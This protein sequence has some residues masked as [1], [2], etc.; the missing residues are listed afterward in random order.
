MGEGGEFV[1]FGEV[2][3]AFF[4]GDTGLGDLG[5]IAAGDDDFEGGFL[6]LELFGELESGDAFGHDHIGDEEVELVLVLVPEVEGLG[7]I[8][9]GGDLVTEGAEAF[10]H[11]VAEGGFVFDD[12]EGFGA[13]LGFGFL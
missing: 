5:A 4:V 6:L 11:G 3:D 9:G 13:A 12:E 7:C 1:G 10:G 8:G 2:G